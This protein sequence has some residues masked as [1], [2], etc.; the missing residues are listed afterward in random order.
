MDYQYENL[1]QDRFQQF[2][3]ALL[4]C[5][6]PNI[7]CL[8]VGQPDGGRDAFWNLLG[9]P[10]SPFVVYQVKYVKR[11]NAAQEPWNWL[12][13]I[14]KGELPKVQKLIQKGAKKYVLITNVPGTAHLDSGSIDKMNK[15]LQKALGI[16]AICLWRDD[17]S[18]RLEKHPQLRWSYAELITGSDL[19]KELI[20]SNLGERKQSRIHAIRAFLTDQFT[21]DKEVRFKQIELQND[22]LDLFTDV[23]TQVNQRSKSK[24]DVR[25]WNVFSLL[26]KDFR[27]DYDTT[28]G[29][30]K[31]LLNPNFQTNF[32]R[33]LMEGAPGQGKS[34]ITQF[35]AQLH[36]MRLLNKKLGNNVPDEYKNFQQRLPFKID[37]RDLASW[38]GGRNPFVQDETLEL[39]TSTERSLET[40]LAAQIVHHS[41]GADFQVSD[42]HAVFQTSAPLIV[43]DG[44]DE[45]ADLARRS[46]VIK[47]IKRGVNRI[48]NIAIGMQVIVTSRPSAFLTAPAFPDDF[49][50]IELLPIKSF[51]IEHYS[52]KWMKAKQLQPAD[53]KE[54]RRILRD[55]LD[56]PHLSELAKNTMQLAILLSLIHS[57]G[58]SLPDKRTALY[59]SYMDLFFSRE[60]EKSD[61]VRDHRDLLIDI[62]RYLAWTLHAEAESHVQKR[63]S[64]SAAQL[65]QLLHDYLHNEQ[66]EEG[67]AESLFTSMV[68]RVVA[69]VS[70]VEGTFEFEV[71]PLREYFA[72]RHLYDTAPYSP[73]GAEK[74][75]T[76][77]DRFDA[78]A[79]NSYWLNVTRFYAG[80]FSKG[81]LPALVDRLE[82]LVREAEYKY[83]SY[84]RI[85]AAT[86]LNDWVFAQNPR[87]MKQVVELVLDGVGRR[88][89]L[90]SEIRQRHPDPLLNLP[91]RSG[92][93]ELVETC[94]SLLRTGVP[95]DFAPSLVR[96]IQTNTPT[97]AL[98][99]EC[100]DLLKSTNGNEFDKWVYHSF[101]LGILSKLSGKTL[102]DLWG[103][104]EL[105]PQH[106]SHLLNGGQYKFLEIDKATFELVATQILNRETV[107]FRP[108]DHVSIHQLLGFYVNPHAYRQAYREGNSRII[109]HSQGNMS[110]NWNLPSLKDEDKKYRSGMAKKI[111]DYAK[112]AKTSIEGRTTAWVTELDPW[113]EVI[114]KGRSLFGERWAF[115]ELANI[116]AGITSKSEKASK[117]NDLLDSKKPLT[118]RVRYARL[119]S[120]SPR[121]WS[122]TLDRAIQPQERMLCAIVLLSWGSARTIIANS[123]WLAEYSEAENAANWGK[124]LGAT[125][126]IDRISSER[127]SG[128]ELVF[129][130]CQ[131]LTPRLAVGLWQRL[132]WTTQGKVYDC[133]LSLYEG[134]EYAVLSLCQEFLL[135]KVGHQLLNWND[136]LPKIAET[137]TKGV[138]TN[139]LTSRSVFD[140]MPRHMTTEVAME[141]LEHSNSYPTGLVTAA[142]LVF[143]SRIGESARPV[144]D[145]SIE[146]QWF[147]DS[148]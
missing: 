51:Q 101:R 111:L 119:R 134:K 71:Q 82:E 15:Q 130:D 57:R 10:Q 92:R 79:R 17:L 81:E 30:A 105:K 85:L 76:K 143:R 38:I 18:A 64:I 128:K 14:I 109:V 66:H 100:V 48:E 106:V 58:S 42:L 133:V 70:R 37:L 54:V 94:M 35:V 87:S 39:D 110:A 32:P 56:Q 69:I 62:H 67:L 5:E 125:K 27:F 141:I 115:Y 93:D 8:P 26:E 44:L 144:L 59:D 73:P 142:E 97:D 122:E 72:A 103:E 116:A 86:L 91:A 84:P 9:T 33:T 107:I 31:A 74:R 47:E 28:D 121:W 22:L 46:D 2:C 98:R 136:A 50:Y 1:G 34:T 49:I 23:P 88:Y 43:C 104:R 113:R 135:K 147:E 131:W 96:I 13:K 120:G 6:N 140:R 21:Q 99:D 145:V 36:R 29:C 126:S 20:E 63:G 148:T 117:Y 112:T 138:T 132:A 25:N 108:R 61:I 77:P 41:G 102:G 90:G 127:R 3:Q 65:R 16:P 123:V 40:F 24:K 95:S 129:D 12:N 146:Q 89:F 55:K 4:V 137:Y 19:L 53:A 118:D 45:I 68:E 83:T 78:I 11:P 75:G 60:A 114:E 139:S 80:C 124:V 52:E 7:Q